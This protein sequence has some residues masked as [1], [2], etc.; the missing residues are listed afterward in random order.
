MIHTFITPYCISK[1]V[2]FSFYASR[3]SENQVNKSK[4]LTLNLYL[5]V[6]IKYQDMKIEKVNI[7]GDPYVSGKNI[8]RPTTLISA[9]DDQK[10]KNKCYCI[11][12]FIGIFG[13]KKKNGDKRSNCVA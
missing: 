1:D 3:N 7:A 5:S 10:E 12:R 9:R 8:S 6:F 2:Y 13:R 11:Y 4:L